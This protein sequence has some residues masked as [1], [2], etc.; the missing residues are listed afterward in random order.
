M[1]PSLCS[2]DQK[3]S[4][5]SGSGNRLAPKNLWSIS[6][7]YTLLSVTSPFPTSGLLVS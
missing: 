1:S 2:I 7:Y 5:D 6:I 4:P 3:T